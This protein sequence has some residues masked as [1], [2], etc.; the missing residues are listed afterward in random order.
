M[1]E[2]FV[3][4]LHVVKGTRGHSLKLDKVGCVRDY[5]SRSGRAMKCSGP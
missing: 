3:K 1:S 4:N 2:L 5:F